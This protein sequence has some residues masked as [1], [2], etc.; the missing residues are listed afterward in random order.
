HNFGKNCRNSASQYFGKN[1][2]NSAMQNFG[3][4]CRNSASQNFGKKHANAVPS[5]AYVHM[6]LLLERQLMQE[7]V[8][9]YDGHMNRMDLTT[10]RRE[11]RQ[12]VT[13]LLVHPI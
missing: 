9:T 7:P 10:F 13:W 2:R 3:K 4:N 6:L 11:L 1:C 5:D 12:W 8:T